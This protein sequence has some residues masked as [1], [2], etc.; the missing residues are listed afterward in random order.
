MVG[1]ILDSISPRTYGFLTI[2]MEC[3]VR[4]FLSSGF[5][6]SI[7][8]SKMRS[9]RG[10]VAPDMSHRLICFTGNIFS[11]PLQS[12]HQAAVPRIFSNVDVCPR[13]F[14]SSAIA[15]EVFVLPELNIEN[16]I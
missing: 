2:Q 3:L 10:S 4:A 15:I 11:I 14:I 8:T 12:S 13:E 6:V 16:S 5:N 7:P 9:N 1:K